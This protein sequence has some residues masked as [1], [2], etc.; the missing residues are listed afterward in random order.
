MARELDVLTDTLLAKFRRRGIGMG[1][2]SASFARIVS[3]LVTNRPG[4]LPHLDTLLDALAQELEGN[5][6][7]QR[8]LL[9]AGLV[10]MHTLKDAAP[11]GAPAP[12]PVLHEP[13]DCCGSVD[14]D[15]S[16]C[17]LAAQLVAQAEPEPPPPAPP[18][19]FPLS[20]FLTLGFYAVLGLE[21]GCTLPAIKKAY[22]QLCLTYHPDKGGETET[23]KFIALVYEVLSDK[24]KRQ[25][26][27]REGKS[28]FMGAFDRGP[29]VDTSDALRVV[30]EAVNVQ[31]EELLDVL[32]RRAAGLFAVKK[33]ADWLTG[34]A[35]TVGNLRD[36]WASLKARA[37][38][39]GNLLVVWRRDRVYKH[40][41]LPG[42]F[43]SGVR[44]PEDV[45]E[46]FR[47]RLVEGDVYKQTASPFDLYPRAIKE[48]FRLG[49][50]IQDVDQ[51]KC[52]PTAMVARH[53]WSIHLRQ[54]AEACGA[55]E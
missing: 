15:L 25:Q 27:D 51:P 24:K 47:S 31:S 18:P 7:E 50:D 1:L 12:A 5:Q 32:G 23:F 36:I 45:P 16:V 39:A 43:Y 44:L 14:H 29:G 13:C 30:L 19:R 46:E 26:Y 49:L 20:H 21:P 11:P 42:R 48:L 8:R 2:A 4:A 55:G 37:G 34:E 33:E 28:A 53:P 41:G 3:D 6:R 54:W 10:D 52:F 38:D 17:P 35:Q 9:V 40:T 22:H